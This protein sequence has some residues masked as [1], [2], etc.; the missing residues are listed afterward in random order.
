MPSGTKRIS[1]AEDPSLARGK[2]EPAAIPCALCAVLFECVLR[3]L[4]GALLMNF[5][6]SGGVSN[7]CVGVVDDEM[8]DIQSYLTFF[9]YLSLT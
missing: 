5:E 9:C 2:A 8:K 4:C 3:V 6:Y 1:V 7:T